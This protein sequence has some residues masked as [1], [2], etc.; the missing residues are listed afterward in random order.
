[1]AENSVKERAV[2]KL[3]LRSQK[4]VR[5]ILETKERHACSKL[6]C[7]NTEKVGN[8]AL[9]NVILA[10]LCFYGMGPELL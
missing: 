2:K 9:E 8:N 3:M 1:M 5:G 4:T 7:C 10:H 6:Y